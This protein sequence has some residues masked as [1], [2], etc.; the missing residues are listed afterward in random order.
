MSW[1]DAL[2]S[3]WQ[4]GGE[5]ARQATLTAMDSARAGAA[6]VQQ[7]VRAASQVAGFGA[8]AAGEFAQAAARG[9]AQAGEQALLL[10]PLVGP[11]YKAAKAAL[12]PA[13]PPRATLVEPC[14][15]SLDCKLRRLAQRQQL[16]KQGRAPGASREQQAAAERLARNNEAVELARLSD[17][18]YAQYSQPPV[19]QPPLGWTRMDDAALHAKGIDPKLLEKSKAVIYQTPPDWPGGQKT[20]LAFRGTEPSEADDLKTNLDQ[21]FGKETV[22]YRAATELGIKIA[23][24]LDQNTLVTGHSLGGGK[25]QAAGIK[26]GLK[27]MMFNAAGLHPSTVAG[28]APPASQFL[29]YRTTGDPLTAVQNSAAL[30]SAATGVAGAVGMPLGTGVAAGRFIT[31]QLGLPSL[32]PDAA[33]LAGQGVTAF[34]QSLGNLTRQGYLLPPARGQVVEVPALAENGTAV[35]PADLDGQHSVRSL[36][37]GIEQEK[38]QDIATLQA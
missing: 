5:R 37:N 38:S 31:Q 8:Q 35:A 7:A 32:G 3:A 6:G 25:A 1:S 21:A 16:I 17:D 18:V 14:P 12:S 26:G 28:M 10:H 29:Q 11:T 13:R 36:I 30:Q 20:V 22:Q 34:A 15:N 9:A 33:A 19:N 24:K 2:T 4:A 23:N 27:G